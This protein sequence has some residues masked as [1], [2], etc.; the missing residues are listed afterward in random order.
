M[1]SRF[2]SI[3]VV[4]TST[5]S[6]SR[7]YLAYLACLDS[8]CKWA[9]HVIIVDGGTSDDS[10]EILKQWTQRSN[11]EVYH[12]PT[13]FWGGNGLWHAA[14]WTINTTEGL[15]KLETDWAFIINSDYVLDLRT[16]HDVRK[17]L[18]ENEEAL[19]A[20]FRR[21]KLTNEGNFYSVYPGVALNLKKLREKGLI[22]GFGVNSQTNQLS[23]API[24]LRQQ[25]RFI[26]ANKSVKTVFRGDI[27]KPDMSLDLTSVV[28]GH[29]FFNFDQLVDKLLDFWLVYQVRYAKRATKSRRMFIFEFGLTKEGSILPKHVELAKPHP[30]EVKKLIDH[31]YRS[32]M[33]GHGNKLKPLPVQKAIRVYQKIRSIIFQK[34]SFPSVQDV[35][36][37]EELNLDAGPTLDLAALYARQDEYL[38]FG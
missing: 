3:G 15:K 24:Y 38:K 5:N 27:M 32:D 2:P 13:T 8:W 34:S 7:G 1:K 36:R 14:Q 29:F 18:G 22:F 17:T 10:Y 35:Q 30:P 20:V 33:I 23:D 11:W 26:D 19:C 4:T 25:T 28:Y 37:W 31:F 9:D 6:F 16:V 12:S 21:V